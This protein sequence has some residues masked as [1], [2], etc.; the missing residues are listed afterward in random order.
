[1]SFDVGT[2]EAA[3]E[4]VVELTLSSSHRVL[5]IVITDGDAIEMDQE[6]FSNA[7]QIGGFIYSEDDNSIVMETASN[8]DIPTGTFGGDSLDSPP[9]IIEIEVKNGEDTN[10]ID[11]DDQIIITFNEAIDPHSIDNDLELDDYITNVDDDDT[12]GVI[13]DDD[14]LLTVTEIARFFVGGVGDDSEFDVRLDLNEIGNI[15]TITLESGTAVDIVFEDLS[16]AEQLGGTIEDKDGETMV[17]D[18]RIDD[19]DLDGSF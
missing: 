4:F 10:Y 9:Y 18:P 17:D 12:G 13:V 7:T 5:T 1:V 3:G 6:I 8:I 15:L 16:D 19:D 11:V 14:G 2:V